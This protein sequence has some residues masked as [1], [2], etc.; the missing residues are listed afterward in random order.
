[1]RTHAGEVTGSAYAVRCMPCH[2]RRVVCAVARAVGH[3]AGTQQMLE[4]TA[5]ELRQLNQLL[6]ALLA[7]LS[8]PR[9][10]RALCS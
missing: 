3:A 7:S 2:A 4:K 1:M 9:A 6:Q 5:K 8:P 10:A